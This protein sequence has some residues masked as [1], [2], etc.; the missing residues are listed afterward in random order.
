MQVHRDAYVYL[1]IDKPRDGSTARRRRD[2]TNRLDR[3]AARRNSRRV[4]LS[5]SKGRGTSAWKHTSL[6]DEGHEGT[7]EFPSWYSYVLRLPEEAVRYVVG[8]NVK[9]PSPA[10]TTTS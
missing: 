10:A 8:R 3:P 2:Q 5:L 6:E 9:E 4:V 7:G 1:V